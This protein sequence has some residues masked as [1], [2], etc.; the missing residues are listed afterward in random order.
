ME[1]WS[2]DGVFPF[3]ILYIFCGRK[4]S[5]YRGGKSDIYAHLVGC[6]VN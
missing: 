6:E 2:C 5:E 3:P 1:A 4:M